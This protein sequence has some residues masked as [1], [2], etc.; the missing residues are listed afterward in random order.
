MKKIICIILALLSLLC[1]FASCGKEAQEESG[2]FDESKYIGEALLTEF[3]QMVDKNQYFY[4]KVFVLGHLAV[5][6][7]STKEVDGKT[8]ALVT[9][10]YSTYEELKNALLLIY[11]KDATNAI[12][13][14]YDY[15]K[16]IDGALYFDMSMD[17]KLSE[18]KGTKWERDYMEKVELEEKVGYTCTLEY[19]FVYDKKDEMDEFTFYRMGENLWRFEELHKVD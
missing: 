4:N 13:S 9:E 5:D 7:E 16:D 6:T 2:A 19:H 3:N 18:A 10:G 15:Y 8:Y 12:L 1:I 11:T 14:E 17:K